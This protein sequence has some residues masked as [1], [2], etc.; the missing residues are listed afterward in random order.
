MLNNDLAPTLKHL[1]R[2]IPVQMECNPALFEFRRVE[3]RS[4]VAAFDGGRI[5]SDAGALLLGAANRVMG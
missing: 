4:V 2:I 3:S 1:L 5:T